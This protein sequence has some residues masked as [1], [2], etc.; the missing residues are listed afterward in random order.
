MKKDHN[1][2][3]YL[4]AFIDILGQKEAFQ[5]INSVPAEGEEDLKKKII[6][7]HKQ[8][9]QFVEV[10]RE[11]FNNLFG[12]SKETKSKIEVPDTFKKQFNEI[13]KVSLK[14]KRF[15][16]CILAFVPFQ[17]D[18]YHLNA[19]NGIRAIITSCGAMLLLSLSDG[20]AF[21]AGIEVG[22]GTELENGEVYGPALFKAYNLESKIA[23]YPRIVIG[24]ELIN[25]LI[26]LSKKNP[27]MPNQDPIGIELCKITADKCLEM[28]IKDF[29][30]YNIV[31]YLGDEIKKIYSHPSVN[32][33]ISYE[34]I[35]ERASKFVEEEYQKRKKMKDSKLALRYYLLSNYFKIK[36][37]MSH[38]TSSNKTK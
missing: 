36:T 13:R 21:R 14:H 1:Y 37:K 3:Y 10:F 2:C 12:V 33:K 26:N 28:I 31:D 35:F 4:V 27:Q 15:S 30:G 29:D 6:E 18:K 32:Y 25:Y 7:A 19:V 17:T 24:P 38:S 34:E 20:K 16:D 5:G 8:T 11:S 22:L 9:V 23:Q